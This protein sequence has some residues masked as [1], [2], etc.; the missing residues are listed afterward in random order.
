MASPENCMRD[1]DLKITVSDFGTLTASKILSAD[2]K[3]SITDG[4]FGIGFTPSDRLTFQAV[5]DGKIPKKKHCTVEVDTAPHVSEKLGRF[6]VDECSRDGSVLTVTAFDAMY[7][8]S[9]AKVRFTG[10]SSRGI[11]PLSFPC[12]MQDVLDY[13]C[14]LRNITCDFT[15]GSYA[16]AKCPQ[17]SENEYYSAREII[18]F[19]AGAH[20]CNAKFD[21]EGVLQFVSFSS[22]NYSATADKIIDMTLDDSEP[23]TV[24]GILYEIGDGTSIYIKDGTET[25]FDA[26]DAGVI[27]TYN[28][29]ATVEIAEDVWTQ[30]GGLSYYGGSITKR[31][32]T[33][34]WCGDV[35]TVSNLKYPADTGTYS[36]YVT[37]ISYSFSA[38]DGF[39]ETIS[40]Q[41]DKTDGYE[42]GAPSSSGSG[43]V[44]EY[45]DDGHTCERFNDYREHAEYDESTEQWSFGGNWSNMKYDHAEGFGNVVASAPRYADFTDSGYNHSEGY[46][47]RMFRSYYSHIGGRQNQLGYYNSG[48]NYNYGATVV[49]IQNI[50]DNVYAGI[51]GGCHNEAK[52]W[53][54][55]GVVL[56]EGNK[57]GYNMRSAVLG[58][59]NEVENIYNS[60]VIGYRNKTT[61]LMNSIILGHDNEGSGEGAII[62]GNCARPGSSHRI[63]VG[64]GSGGNAFTVDDSG[65]VTATRYDTRGADYAEYFE[66]ADGN[67]DNEDRCG[68]LVEL[69]GDK[70]EPAHG[71]DI[72]GIVSAAPSVAGNAY[73]T[74]WHGKYAHDIY[75]RIITTPGGEPLISPDF[76][77]GKEYIPRSKRPEW[78]AVGM[79]G[80]LV[81]NDDGS[82][83]VG[84]YVSARNGKGA[85]SQKKTG[86]IVLRRIDERHVEVFIK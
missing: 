40:S 29:L 65:V 55:Y 71:D 74:E 31:G 10:N 47:N 58:Q 72:F 84:G 43:G 26:D 78:A 76:D 15:C 32:D 36:M 20:G 66:W 68:M 70:I 16:V 13:V 45:L 67:S 28:P 11:A 62:C 53:Q 85:A 81:I 79:T 60:I 50:A 4:S 34:I 25:E 3:R 18:G 7:F 21:D 5:A 69:H 49:G 73:E 30:I 9:K 37:D 8:Q 56:G 46:Q 77:P 17:K 57:V 63:V 41:A 23:F 48:Y 1:I 83:K 14:A 86:V 64:N 82:C 51:V 24:N 33:S 59:S 61:S 38:Q 6:Y 27:K 22:N 39:M 19:I 52:N 42:T 12:S 2:I 54:Y 75:G 44:G 80:R 35:L